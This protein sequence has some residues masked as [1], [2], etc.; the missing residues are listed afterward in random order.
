[1]HHA[2]I[3]VQTSQAEGVSRVLRE[4]M[5]MRLP[6][7]SFDISGTRD[8]LINDR[9]A[10]LVRPNDTVA[11]SHSI[12]TLLSDKSR[13]QSLCKAAFEKY[14]RRHSRLVYSAKLQNM[15]QD[16]VVDAK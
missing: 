7:V 3:L 9:E 11:M 1:M 4:A 14:Q 15:I 16:I 10:L 6:I 12:A 2:D 5:F 13:S 8:I